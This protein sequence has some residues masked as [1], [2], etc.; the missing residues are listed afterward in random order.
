MVSWRA[1]FGPRGHSRAGSDRDPGSKTEGQAVA[2]CE[3]QTEEP[4]ASTS[5]APSGL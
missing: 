2:E 1:W 3:K 4:F 5:T